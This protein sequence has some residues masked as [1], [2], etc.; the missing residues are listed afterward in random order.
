MENEE[1]PLP[2]GLATFYSSQAHLLLEQYNNINQ[3]LGPTKDWGHPGTHCEVLVRDFLRKN[4]LNWMSV[5]KGYIYGRTPRSGKISH[6]PEIDIL[7][8]NVH[9]YTPIFRMDDFVIVQPEAVMGMIQVKRTF[10]AIGNETPLEKGLRQAIEAK[11]HWLD[12]IV[13]SEPENMANRLGTRHFLMP[14]FSGVVAFDETKD[15]SIGD[16]IKAFYRQHLNAG[17][18]QWSPAAKD[19]SAFVMPNFVGSLSGNCAYSMK[20]PNY[21][22]LYEAQYNGQNIALQ[23]LL[24]AILHKS[25]GSE[26]IRQKP[27]SFPIMPSVPK[28]YL[29]PPTQPTTENPT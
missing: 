17:H 8:H 14:V 4:M 26:A 2:H 5:D 18:Y 24:F 28:L 12:L 13:G 6:C 9:D 23:L 25:V 16:S 7:I 11:Q 22:N 29:E 3:L 1:D 20:S 10:S 19:A 15:V 21:F 27:F